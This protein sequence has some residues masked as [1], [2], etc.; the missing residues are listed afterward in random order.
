MDTKT[1][2]LKILP[3]WLI[4]LCLATGINLAASLHYKTPATEPAGNTS[5]PLVLGDTTEIRGS[6]PVLTE[7]TKVSEPDISSVTAKSFLV[8]D[9]ATGKEVMERFK[10]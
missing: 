4:F 1:K 2:I 7:L 9:L 5:Q 3:F 8:F 10:P 6:P